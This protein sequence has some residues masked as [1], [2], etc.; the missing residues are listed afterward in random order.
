MAD[1]AEE[2][3]LKTEGVRK[4]IKKIKDADALKQ[5]IVVATYDAPNQRLVLSNIEFIVPSEASATSEPA[6]TEDTASE[7]G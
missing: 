5:D 2:K 6:V 4:L 7:E 1:I 3:V